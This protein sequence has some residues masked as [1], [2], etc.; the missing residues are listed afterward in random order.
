MSDYMIRAVAAEEQIR[1]FAITS[2]ELVEEARRRHNTSPVIT[3]ALGRLLSGGAMMGAMMKGK[4]D[5]LTVKIDCSGPVKGITVTADARGNVKGFPL[6]PQVSLPASSAGK[7]D[8][9]R[10]VD[11]G[12]LTVIRDMGLKEPY[13]GSINLV[14]GEIAEDL[15]YYYAVSEQ[16]PSSV[17]LGVLM[18]KD[19]TVRESG[20]YMIQLMPD[21]SEEVIT[22]LEERLKN[23]ES[24][25]TMYTKGYTPESMLEYI[26]EGFDL[27]I[28][29]KIPVR[30]HCGCSK[31][32][33]RKALAA[34]G[35]KELESLIEEGTPVEMNCHF[36]NSDYSFETE[37]LIEIKNSLK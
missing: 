27:E 14:S 28:T 4:K 34:I 30:F 2:R 12:V 19:N 33:V 9:G 23:I 7:L 18:N 16:T 24:V 8:V 6:V 37:E 5:L 3:A 31:E 10:A 29:E 26:L 1:C 13:S 21:S 11:L 15:T 35:K 22:I 36:C 20:G 32:R 25:T 17:A